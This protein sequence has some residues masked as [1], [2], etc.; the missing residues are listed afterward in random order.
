M[1]DDA[2]EVPVYI[3]VA[4]FADQVYFENCIHS[5]PDASQLSSGT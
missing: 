3:N 4:R 5:D 2:G 1:R